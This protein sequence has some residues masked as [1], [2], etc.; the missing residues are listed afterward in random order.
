LI[1]LDE[2]PLFGNAPA[3]PWAPFSS[4]LS[5]LF[6]QKDLTIKPAEMEWKT[7]EQLLN[8]LGSHLQFTNIVFSGLDGTLTWVISKNEIDPLMQKLLSIPITPFA[9]LDKDF[10]AGFYHFAIAQI[11][12][13]I[14]Q[15]DFDKNLSPSLAETDQ[16]PAKEPALCMD[17]AI[18]I[19]QQPF[20][21]RLIISQALRK[22]WK[23]RYADR[24]L[25]TWFA[26]SLAQ[27]ANITVHLEAGKTELLPSELEAVAVGDYIILDSCTYEPDADK[28][29]VMMTV[30]GI[31]LFRAKLK[32]GNL[33]IL[34]FPLYHE[35]QRTMNN[36]EN[37]EDFEEESEIEESEI[38]E[39]ETDETEEFL[40]EETSTEETSEIEAK[41]ETEVEKPA[42]AEP[43]PPPKE[44]KVS[45]KDL[46]VN[47][48]IEVGRIQ[49]SVQ[50]LMEL[51]PGNMLELD[52]SPENGVDLVVNGKRIGKGELIRIGETLGL[53][54]LDLG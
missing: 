19:Q 22:S 28:V 30:N 21:G 45:V 48:V 3:F 12:Q 26:G 31:P 4:A 25:S 8:G 2:K 52:I 50:K 16:E 6:D 43:S 37:D 7:A 42:K 41:K 17:I 51:S 46:P 29:R 33:K 38:E 24:K 20:H 9:A 18:T 39:S 47:V 14:K 5:K 1:E 34:E 13:T 40:E 53:R 11:L 54:V 10:E 15:L 44:G 36:K 27:K 35:E 23:E 49:M 32:Q